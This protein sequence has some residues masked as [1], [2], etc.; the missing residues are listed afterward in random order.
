M[1]TRRDFL[2]SSA[3]AS[4]LTIGAYAGIARAQE[5]KSANEKIV[6][7]VMGL[8][9][10]AAHAGAFSTLMGSEVGYLCD[11]DSRTLGRSKDTIGKR[12]KRQPQAVVDVRRI[13]DDKSV[14]V[15]SIAA[16]DHWHAPATILACSAGKHVYVE[17]PCSHNPREGELAVEAARKH[18]RVVQMGSQRRSW[19]GVIKGIEKLRAGVIGR[20]MFSNAWYNNKRPS[21]GKG[22]PAPVPEWLNYD[23]WQGPAPLREFRD[24]LVHYNWHW[25]WHWGTGELGNNGVHALDISR[26]GVGVDYPTRVAAGGGKYRHDD[27]QETPD[28][29]NV[30]YDFGDKSIAWQGLS[31]SPRGFEGEGFGITFHGDKGTMVMIDSGYVVYDMSNKEMEKG[32]GRASDDLHFEN[33]LTCIRE[34]KRPNADIEEGHKTTL[35]CH[36]GNIS[37]RTGKT[38]HCDPKTGRILKDED[39]M[40]LWTREY[41]QGWEPKV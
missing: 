32:T 2:Q 16:P 22:K 27:D 4:A 19:E 39:A 15:L 30:T 34:H 9:R 3:A 31:W 17:K 28:T 41:R 37:W 14:D 13:L 6:V 5:P 26:W 25:F 29:H 21:I 23:L 20:V 38:L 33:F 24:N 11:V 40:K 12:Q 8:N 36:L 1:T 10:G 18:D 7:G 35:L